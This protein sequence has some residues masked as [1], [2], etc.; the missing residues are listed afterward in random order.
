LPYLA[1]NVY[2]PDGYTFLSYLVNKNLTYWIKAALEIDGI[3]YV[4]DKN[5]TT[6][7]LLAIKNKNYK[8]MQLLLDFC[9]KTQLSASQL[10]QE[11][12]K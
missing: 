12:L 6:P 5:G 4:T 2:H 11:E 3:K 7:L 10:T 1:K 9:C 8:I